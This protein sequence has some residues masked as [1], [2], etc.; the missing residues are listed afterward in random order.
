[1]LIVEK[2]VHQVRFLVCSVAM[3]ILHK[4]SIQRSNNAVFY[5]VKAAT[6]QA[7]NGDALLLSSANVTTTISSA[8]ISVHFERTTGSTASTDDI[9]ASIKA[10][11]RNGRMCLLCLN[12]SN[13]MH[14]VLADGYN[15]T[16]ENFLDWCL[17]ADSAGGIH[18]TL[19]EAMIKGGFTQSNSIVVS[20]RVIN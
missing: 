4:G 7:T 17:V 13:H 1:M 20:A 16:Y 12:Q 18:R 2:P 10:E 8:S 19:R 9:V 3:F 6:E 14:F 15:N 5:A 11:L